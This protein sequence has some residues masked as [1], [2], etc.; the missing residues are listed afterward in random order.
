MMKQKN[1]S[2]IK[3]FGN[4]T[5]IHH[6]SFVCQIE[7]LC[8]VFSSVFACSTLLESKIDIT[9]TSIY[10]DKAEKSEKY[11]ILWQQNYYSSLKIAK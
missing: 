10:H 9:V 11:K 7:L 2:N 4:K 1:L 5:I 6:N 8:Q 3:C